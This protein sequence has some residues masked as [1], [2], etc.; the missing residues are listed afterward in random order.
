[1]GMDRNTGRLLTGLAHVQQSI[2]DI[3]ITP[4]GS[5]IERRH[6][7][8]RLFDLI[9]SPTTGSTTLDVFS[10]VAE[11]LRP[12]VIDGVQYG[13]PRIRVTRIRFEA[14]SNIEGGMWPPLM[15]EATLLS[16]GRPVTLRGIEI[17]ELQTETQTGT[18]RSSAYDEAYDEAYG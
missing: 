2:R 10:A 17:G 14:V 5:R 9:D 11:A 16:E 15:L 8:S 1:M 4:L 6:Y 18:L 12:R 13:E 3:L 7:G